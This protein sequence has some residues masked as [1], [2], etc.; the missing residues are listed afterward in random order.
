MHVIKKIFPLK[1]DVSALLLLI[2]LFISFSLQAQL[3]P[4]INVRVDANTGNYAVTSLSLKWTMSGS[5]GK[6]LHHLKV[7]RE[8]MLLGNIPRSLFNG[9]V[10]T[11]ILAL[12][13]GM[14]NLQYY[15]FH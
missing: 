12:S 2:F 6:A 13:D 11:C 9:K 7:K 8:K 10:I 5:I 3:K 1:T 15:F 14:L 4:D